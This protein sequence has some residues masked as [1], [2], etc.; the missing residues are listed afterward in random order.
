MIAVFALCLTNVKAY[1]QTYFFD[2]LPNIPIAHGITDLPDQA[3]I[4]DKANGRIVTVTA[5]IEPDTQKEDITSYY[6]S[7]LPAFGWHRINET[8]YKRDTE[9]LTIRF[10]SYEGEKYFH[11]TIQP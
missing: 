5:L 6:Q 10:D 11:L 3:N 2:A 4:F 7:A 8:T 1:A 9:Q